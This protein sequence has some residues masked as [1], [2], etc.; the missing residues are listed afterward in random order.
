MEEYKALLHYFC[1]LNAEIAQIF[2][3]M[4]LGV[5]PDESIQEKAEDLEIAKN[6][7]LAKKE[8]LGLKGELTFLEDFSFDTGNPLEKKSADPVFG[9]KD[10]L[11]F[12]DKE[13]AFPILEK[14]YQSTEE[15]IKE[16]PYRYEKAV[17]LFT[18][19]Y[20][21]NEETINMEDATCEEVA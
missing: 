16:N 6:L 11:F 13:A 3:S 17:Y 9:I 1:F 5:C 18:Y 10:R 7:L 20:W 4:T 12:G 15:E 2:E 14:W 21:G 19:L 8:E